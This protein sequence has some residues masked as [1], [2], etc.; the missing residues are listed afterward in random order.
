MSI[1]TSYGKTLHYSTSEQINYSEHLNINGIDGRRDCVIFL[2]MVSVTES[3][4]TRMKHHA[5][6]AGSFD[7][8]LEV[9]FT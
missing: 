9:L 5:E 8:F 1:S 4:K 2:E 7:T 3:Y 6:N